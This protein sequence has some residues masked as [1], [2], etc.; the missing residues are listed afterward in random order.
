MVASS[1]N[2]QFTGVS[3]KPPPAPA[4]NPTMSSINVLL[5]NFITLPL[6]YS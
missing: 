4:E 1:I 2:F 3:I 5:S 6:A